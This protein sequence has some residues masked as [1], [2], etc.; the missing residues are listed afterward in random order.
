MG[1]KFMPILYFD[2]EGTL[3]VC[4]PTNFGP[5][6]D[7]LVITTL[8]I[9]QNGK[10]MSPPLPIITKAPAEEWE[11]EIPGAKGQLAVGKA[12]GFASGNIVKKNGRSVPVSWPGDLTL[13]DG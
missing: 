7:E 8:T 13:S 9:K 5:N 2:C 6:D 11:G 10:T 12:T 3:E 1:P 4:G